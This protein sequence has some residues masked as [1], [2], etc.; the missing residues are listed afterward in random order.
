MTE[1]DHIFPKLNL[2]EFQVKFKISNDNLPLIFDVVR[3][4]WLQLTP[5][6]WVRQHWINYLHSEIGVPLPLMEIEGG[7]KVNHMQKR[8]DLLAY[9]NNTPFLLLECK[10][11]EIPIDEKVFQQ[12][13]NY[14][15]TI[16]AQLLILSNGYHHKLLKVDH[17]LMK[18]EEIDN[19]P[20]FSEWN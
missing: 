16:S 9:A 3:K 7:K 8:T 13:L 6:E 18:I 14:N 19:I 17:A 5:E 1:L 12:I 2:P 15:K 20:H 10:A 4:K 11:P